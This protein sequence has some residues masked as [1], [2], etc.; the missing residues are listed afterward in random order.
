MHC[1]IAT[2]PVSWPPWLATVATFDTDNIEC[3]GTALRW[4]YVILLRTVP[5]VKGRAVFKRVILTAL[6]A[7]FSCFTSNLVHV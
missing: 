5:E 7:L 1:A 3:I 2:L 6:I 4:G